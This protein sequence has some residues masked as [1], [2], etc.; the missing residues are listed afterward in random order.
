MTVGMFAFGFALVPL[1][2]VFCE[3]TGFGGRT[4]A[5]PAAVTGI[6]ESHEGRTI[7]VEFASNLSGFGHWD[8]EPAQRTME[9][10]PGRVYEVRFVATNG[11]DNVLTGHAVPSVAPGS[12]ARHFLKTECFCFESQEFAARERREMPVVFT[13]DPQIPRHVD[14][15]TL[16]YTFFPGRPVAA[17]QMNPQPGQ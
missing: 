6:T 16:S 13:I 12:A 8:F 9:V 10:E 3:I 7:A 15:I 4:N 5:T 14:R 2:D 11:S 17:R 1:Y